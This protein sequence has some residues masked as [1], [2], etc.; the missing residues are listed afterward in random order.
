MTQSMEKFA[1]IS[2]LV[3][4][5]A[6]REAEEILSEAHAEA[7]KSV[8][9]KK[10]SLLAAYDTDVARRTEQFRAEEKRRVAEKLYAEERRV[11]LYRASLTDRFF[12]EI[13]R[14]IRETV[15]SPAYSEY[16]KRAAEKANAYAPLNASATVYCRA[17]DLPAVKTMLGAYGVSAETTEEIRLGGFFV[18]YG[19]GNAFLDLSLDTAL[20]RE[21][22]NFSERKELQI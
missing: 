2:E 5:D 17:Q 1:Q 16:L 11:L 18:R 12:S 22:E 15:G 10:K 6:D 9:E 4:N 7:E 13:E 20:E 3:R 14:S 8:S 21:R 19:G